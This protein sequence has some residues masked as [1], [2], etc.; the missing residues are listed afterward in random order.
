MK[1]SILILGGY[2]NAGFL[3]S[4]YLLQETHDVAIIIAGRHFEK[5]QKAADELNQL[6]PGQR[7]SP[8]Q[9]DVADRQIFRDA[10][11]KASLVV[12]ASG[13][14]KHT[15]LVVEEVLNA[16][17]DYFDL[18]LSSP[19]KLDVLFSLKDKIEASGHCF[20]TDGGFHPGVPAALLR[21]A[22][23]MFDSLE[24]ANVYGGLKV[25]WAA[26]DASEG[27]LDELVDEFKYYQMLFLKNGRWKKMS[28][29]AMPPGFDFGPPLGKLY[30]APMFLEELRSLP[31]EIPE[32]KETGFYV[33]GFNPILDYLLLPV[34][35][36]GI[37]IFPE[38]F[39]D[40]F[41]KLF[42]FGL[43]FG[44]PP[45]G[46]KLVADCSG[47]KEG[48]P[49]H[50][51]LSLTHE[52]EYVL[53]AVPVVACLLQYL[54]GAIRKPGLWFQSNVVEPERFFNDMGRMGLPLVVQDVS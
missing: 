11:S 19:V 53:T 54:D 44:K 29:F 38:R 4:K 27:T 8:V 15:K 47:L 35:M 16:G 48:K 31:E 6:F 17:I 36:F 3:I 50:I 37:K 33:S 51:Q 2:G 52:D 21:Y 43:K 25:D 7:T 26:I 18:Q 12:M 34:I 42:Q 24:K 49:K 45:Y 10:L 14:M 20:I 23:G 40:P 30:C 1:K 28:Y 13:T 39:A 46:V 22:A 41:I 9:V 32:L 5:A